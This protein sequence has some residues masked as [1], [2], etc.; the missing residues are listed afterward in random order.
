MTRTKMSCHISVRFC[1]AA[2]TTSQH[3]FGTLHFACFLV[4]WRSAVRPWRFGF[5]T[6]ICEKYGM[7]EMEYGASGFSAC[8]GRLLWACRPQVKAAVSGGFCSKKNLFGAGKFIFTDT[9]S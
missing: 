8:Q 6:N 4:F 5:W 9:V 2:R 7:E 1:K 3:I